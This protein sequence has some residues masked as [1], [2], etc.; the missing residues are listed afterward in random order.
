[1]WDDPTYQIGCFGPQV[2]ENPNKVFNAS[3]NVSQNKKSGGGKIQDP[4]IQQLHNVW[5]LAPF[6]RNS[7]SFSF[8]CYKMVAGPPSIRCSSDCF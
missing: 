2:T 8:S 6:L 1:M 7:H 5:A 4:L 3:R